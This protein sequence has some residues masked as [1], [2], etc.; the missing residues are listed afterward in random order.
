MAHD[1]PSKRAPFDGLTHRC[2]DRATPSIM[3]LRRAFSSDQKYS[4]QVLQRLEKS[5]FRNVHLK[6]PK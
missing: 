1:I 3:E 4:L 5:S 2:I 6:I